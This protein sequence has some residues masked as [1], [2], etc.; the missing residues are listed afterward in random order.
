MGAVR[1]LREDTGL[2]ALGEVF[3]R[4]CEAPPANS[5]RL[6]EMV[7]MAAGADSRLNDHV[8]GNRVLSE[9]RNGMTLGTF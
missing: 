2:A 6:Q 5:S 9:M 1:G 3:R 4:I 7:H 8:G